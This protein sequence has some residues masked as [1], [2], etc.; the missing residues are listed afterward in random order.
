MYLNKI[1]LL[2][3]Q[4]YSRQVLIIRVIVVIMR[5]FYGAVVV[6]RKLNIWWLFAAWLQTFLSCPV[7][8]IHIHKEGESVLVFEQLFNLLP[9]HRLNYDILIKGTK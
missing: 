1:S 7:I 4:I 5:L 2:K 6:L 8:F 3:S 9:K